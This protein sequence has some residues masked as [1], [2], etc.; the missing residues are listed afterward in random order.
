MMAFIGHGES[1]PKATS[2]SDSTPYTATCQRYGARNGSVHCRSDGLGG[3]AGCAPRCVT[4]PSAAAGARRAEQR[5]V[6]RDDAPAARAKR[7]RRR[8][9]RRRRR[10]ESRAGDRPLATAEPIFMALGSA[11]DVMMPSGVTTRTR[12]TDESAMYSVTCF[13]R[14]TSAMPVGADRPA[15]TAGP[16]SPPPPAEPSPATVVILPVAAVDRVARDCDRC[17]RR[18][19]RPSRPPRGPSATTAGPWWRARHHPRRRTRR[20]PDARPGEVVMTPVRRRDLADPM[21]GRV[22]DVEVACAVDRHAG[23]FVQHA[24]WSPGPR[25]RRSPACPVPATT[26]VVP[27]IAIDAKD[28]V[29]LGVRDVEVAVGSHRD[30]ARRGHPTT[31]VRRALAPRLRHRWTEGDGCGAGDRAD[32]T[33]HVLVRPTRRGHRWVRPSDRRGAT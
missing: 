13:R 1:A 14:A 12:P 17:R 31:V 2:A 10:R 7:P 16:P 8:R 33:N 27:R 23:R 32:S 3:G 19:R 22:R 21:V 5:Q 30:A 11:S 6:A 15:F 26:M 18:R 4:S 28:A 25:R 9:L 20:P 29:A 24:P